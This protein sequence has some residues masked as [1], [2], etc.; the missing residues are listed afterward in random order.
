M[1]AVQTVNPSPCPGSEVFDPRRTPRQEAPGCEAPN[2]PGFNRTRQTSR[3]VSFKTWKD[4]LW[5]SYRA[6]RCSRTVAPAQRQ[7]RRTLSVPHSERTQKRLVFLL[8]SRCQ[9]VSCRDLAIGQEGSSSDEPANQI[10]GN[11]ASQKLVE[12]TGIEPVTSCLQSTR[13]PS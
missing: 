8:S 11:A 1:T 3:S 6:L 5:L 9:I 2:D 12:P 7:T 13:S 10:V 4:C